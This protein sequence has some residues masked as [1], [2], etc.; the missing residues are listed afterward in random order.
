LRATKKRGEKF[1][2]KD[3]RFAGKMPFAEDLVEA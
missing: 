3:Q 2:P 1:W